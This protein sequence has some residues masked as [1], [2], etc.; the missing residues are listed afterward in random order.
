[1]KPCELYADKIGNIRDF[2]YDFSRLWKSG[3][4]ARMRARI[5]KE[6]CFCTHECNWTTNILFNPRYAREL[7]MG[8][9]P[10]R[11]KKKNQAGEISRQPLSIVVCA[12]N[13]EV[14]IARKIE[15]I[16]RNDRSLRA[17]EVI[18]VDDYSDDATFEVAQ[19][20]LKQYDR[21]KVVKNSR[22]PGKWQALQCGI[23]EARGEI[24]CMTDADVDFE[25]NTLENALRLFNDPRVGAVSSSQ[26]IILCRDGRQDKPKVCLYEK[27]RNFFRRLE[28]K[29]DST[30]AF[31]GQ[32]M[33]LRKKYLEFNRDNLMADDLDIAIRIR[34]LGLKTIFAPDSYSVEKLSRGFSRG[35]S[36]KI[37]QRRALAVAQ[38]MLSNRDILF[39]QKYGKFGL[40]CFPLEFF[41]NVIL[42]FLAIA[43]LA[44]AGLVLFLRPLLFAVFLLFCFS[45]KD[46]IS[47]VWFQAGAVLTIIF[48]PKAVYGRW[49]TPR[50]QNSN[51]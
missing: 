43:A 33:F 15:D 5:R 19:G 35:L 29:I 7:A 4:A 25:P 47:L 3:A 40:F 9:I 45:I 44:L 20:F 38:T 39:N 18:I 37:F 51:I 16:F 23:E 31:H 48:N 36:R 30:T 42:P 8:S 14:T 34:R 28:S 1:V 32:C 41:I 22:Q 13:E 50:R 26:K 6:K 46:L 27:F 17:Q 11:Q 2:N 24:I 10:G 12:H 49:I 21:L